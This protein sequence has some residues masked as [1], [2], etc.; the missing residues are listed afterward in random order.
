MKRRSGM[1]VK[2]LSVPVFIYQRKRQTPAQQITLLQRKERRLLIK[3]HGTKSPILTFS[4]RLYQHR[5]IRSGFRI[6]NIVQRHQPQLAAPQLLLGLW[7]RLRGG[8]DLTKPPS[9]NF[10]IN[11]AIRHITEKKPSGPLA[12]FRRSKQSMLRVPEEHTD[13]TSGQTLVE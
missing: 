4:R 3:N 12:Q 2:P 8:I 6:K 11:T 5:P 10:Q 7:R 1:G 9:V 13:K